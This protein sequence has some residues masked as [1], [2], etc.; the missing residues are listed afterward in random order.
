MRLDRD[1][2]R[3]TRSC[4]GPYQRG[5]EYA[6][7]ARASY[8]FAGGHTVFQCIIRFCWKRGRLSKWRGCSTVLLS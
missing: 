1:R 4:D 3:M 2:R 8:V 5:M 6:Q 7:G